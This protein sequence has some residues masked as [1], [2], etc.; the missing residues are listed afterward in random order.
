MSKHPGLDLVERA[1]ALQPL[2]SRDADEIERTR[3][4][5]PAV[6]SALIENGLYRVLLPQSLGGTE[7]PLQIFMQMQVEI[8]KADASTAW[9]LGQCNGSPDTDAYLD[10]SLADAI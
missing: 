8:G 9:S 6:T 10:P 2:I 1:R 7:A 5:T 4:L 3:R